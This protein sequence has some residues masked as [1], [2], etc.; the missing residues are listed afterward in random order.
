VSLP[1]WSGKRPGKATLIWF[2]NFTL[3]IYSLY[4]HLQPLDSFVLPIPSFKG[5]TPISVILILAQTP[6][7]ESADD[8]SAGPSAGY[9]RTR[10]G[11]RKVAATPPPPKKLL[12]VANKKRP[13]IKINDLPPKPFPVPTLPKCT[14]GKFTMHWSN[15]YSQHKSF[16]ILNW[17]LKFTFRV[18]LYKILIQ[19][20]M[21]RIPNQAA[22]LPRPPTS[23]PLL[24]EKG[25]PD[26]DQSTRS[27]FCLYPNRSIT[28]SELHPPPL[29]PFTVDPRPSPLQTITPTMTDEPTLF[30]FT[31]PRGK[32]LTTWVARALISG[33]PCHRHLRKSMVDRHWVAVHDPCT[34]STKFPIQNQF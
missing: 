19:T 25:H 23:R 20:L 21:Q 11:K 16:F 3:V 26:L 9:L 8:S 12:K 15:R 29:F 18:G 6:S 17:F 24:Q 5:D 28:P 34:K 32:V 22:T 10:A 33:E 30:R 31:N 2:I 4:T 7:V 14:R 1:S 13:A 27:P